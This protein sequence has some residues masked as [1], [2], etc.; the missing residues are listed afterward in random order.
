MEKIEV[1][2]LVLAN[3]YMSAHMLPIL[4]FHFP[5][6]VSFQTVAIIMCSYRRVMCMLI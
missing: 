2:F 1:L 3:L 5:Q 6:C 4:S